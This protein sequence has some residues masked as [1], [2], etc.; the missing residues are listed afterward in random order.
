MHHAPGTSTRDARCPAGTAAGRTE[1]S[2]AATKA[3]TAGRGWTPRV[4]GLGPTRAPLLA[5]RTTHPRALSPHHG[6]HG[7]TRQPD[8]PGTDCPSSPFARTGGLH[9]AAPAAGDSRAAGATTGC[10]WRRHQPTKGWREGL[11]CGP[12]P[13]NARRGPRLQDHGN[14]TGLWHEDAVHPQLCV[15]ELPDAHCCIRG[16]RAIVVALALVA[17]AVAVALCVE[18]N[19]LGG[20]LRGRRMCG[21]VC[22]P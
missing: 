22:R 7:R 3:T 11:W 4:P 10:G 12:P 15:A 6:R 19:D 8:A 13:A 18:A 2:G 1:L 20:R 9:P 21:E 14:W 16:L 5:R 17:V